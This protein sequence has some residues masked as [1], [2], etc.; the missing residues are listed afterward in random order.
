[1]GVSKIKN[2]L[3]PDSNTQHTHIRGCSLYHFQSERKFDQNPSIRLF[4][5]VTSR[6]GTHQAPP[7]TPTPQYLHPHN[8][9]PRQEKILHPDADRQQ[10]RNFAYYSM[11]HVRPIPRIYSKSVYKIFR[12]VV[13]RQT[14]WQTDRQTERQTNQWLLSQNL[15]QIK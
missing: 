3:D 9:S 7:P 2:D 4:R 13:H 11:Y 8:H 5:N 14:D 12:N 10:P 1:M 15:C 6:T